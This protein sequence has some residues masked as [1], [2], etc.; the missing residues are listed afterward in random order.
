[1]KS[2]FLLLLLIIFSNGLVQAQIEW[3]RYGDNPVLDVGPPGAWDDAMLVRGSVYIDNTTYHMWYSGYDGL[4]FRIGYATSPDGINWQKY[5]SNPV[6]DFGASGTWDDEYVAIP[7]VI[8]FNSQYHMIYQGRDNGTIRL[9]H[10]TSPDG[11][12]WTK[13][14]QNPVIDIG[15]P[16]SW[17]DTWVATPF[18]MSKGDTLHLWF[19]GRQGTIGRIG[20]AFS[21]DEGTSWEFNPNNP[22]LDIGT[23]DTPRVS[24]PSVVYNSITSQYYMI[25]SGG[26]EGIF[27]SEIG[28]ATSSSLF[29]PWT[30]Q[31]NGPIFLKGDPGEWDSQHV[32]F[33]YVI[34]DQSSDT[35]KMWYTGGAAD[36]DSKIGYA[37][38][39]VVTGI[40]DDIS[41][42]MEFNLYQNHPNPFNS[43][44]AIQYSIPQRSNVQL[45]VY[46][47][48]GNEVSTL[49]NEEKE[50]GVYTIN[51]DAN[52]LASGMYL[53]RIQAGSFIDTKKMIL[54]K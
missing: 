26:N 34:F 8:Y 47:I 30:K 44:T 24:S 9:G 51:F 32:G 6:L 3:T 10:A 49:V 31:G 27:I 48:L 2:F 28:F 19:F 15:A 25:Y 1:M 22:V 17:Y 11:I 12:N 16:G 23:W 33:H 7:T 13:D 45:K 52:N 41:I 50:Q 42:P 40:E 18:M 36:W 37:T 46:D 21:T 14:P 53:Y 43:A 4:T 38:A 20:H 29:G 35:Y 5:S 39:P 54:L